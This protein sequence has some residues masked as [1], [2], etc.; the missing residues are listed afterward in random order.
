LVRFVPEADVE[1]TSEVLKLMVQDAADNSDVN[2]QN[3][4]Q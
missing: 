3:L 2:D 1:D 4:L